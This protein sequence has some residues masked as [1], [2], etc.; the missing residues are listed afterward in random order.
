MWIW[1]LWTHSQTESLFMVFSV[2]RKRTQANLKRIYNRYPETLCHPRFVCCSGVSSCPL[3]FI[4]SLYCQKIIP[5]CWSISPW[6][7]GKKPPG[8][9][10]PREERDGA[11]APPMKKR[12]N[13]PLLSQITPT[14]GAL[15][16]T[17]VLNRT[18]FEN[19]SS[20]FQWWSCWLGSFQAEI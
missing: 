20:A 3:N 16:V 10:P 11:S 19:L 7:Q 1:L 6:G 15:P 4:T 8:V 13:F 9:W 12:L 18:Y 17:S 14:S 5:A 2:L